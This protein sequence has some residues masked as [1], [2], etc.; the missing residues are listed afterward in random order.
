MHISELD[1]PALTVDLDILERNIY[2]MAALCREI[3]IDLRVHTKN[4]QSPPRL[5]PCR[6]LPV[7]RG[8]PPKSSAKRRL[9]LMAGLM[10]F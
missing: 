1:T 10:T 6:L 9:W 5:P 7:Q 8:L 2:N 4:P 3:D